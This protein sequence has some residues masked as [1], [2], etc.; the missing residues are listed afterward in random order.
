MILHV[1]IDQSMRTRARNVERSREVLEQKEA[2]SALDASVVYTRLI[3][4]R[5]GTGGSLNPHCFHPSCLELSGKPM[6]ERRFLVC[7]ITL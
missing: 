2:P 4:R 7:C 5:M 1:A 3:H 6:S